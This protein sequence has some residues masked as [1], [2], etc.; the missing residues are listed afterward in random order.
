MSTHISSNGKSRTAVTL[1]EVEDSST[2]EADSLSDFNGESVD[3]KYFPGKVTRSEESIGLQSHDSL[4][5]N[6]LPE[7]KWKEEVLKSLK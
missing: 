3:N 5:M 4:D 7:K 2:E 6:R 1:F